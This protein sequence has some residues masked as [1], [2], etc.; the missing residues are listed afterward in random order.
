MGGTQH[1]EGDRTAAHRRMG[2]DGGGH[3]A[4]GPHGG[5]AVLRHQLRVGEREDLTA[6]QTGDVT[7]VQAGDVIAVQTGDV[8]AVQA[9]DVTAVQ[10]GG[11]PGMGR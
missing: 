3:V 5:R 1:G 9:G 2:I 11:Q 4:Q 10:T 6:V 7:A 8:T